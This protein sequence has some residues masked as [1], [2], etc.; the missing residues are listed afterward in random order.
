MLNKLLIKITT[1]IAVIA[2]ATSS[3]SAFGAGFSLSGK[4][5]SF[6]N[7]AMQA[8]T[9][10][11]VADSVTYTSTGSG[12][13]RTE[14]AAGNIEWA[15]TDAPYTS[16]VPSKGFVTV[17]LVA[18]P[19]AFAY[20]A[21][22]VG[23]GLNLTAEVI[24]GILKGEITR[25]N[26]SKIQSLNPRVKLPKKAIKVVYR[27]SGSGTNSNLTNYLNQTVGNWTKGSSDMVSASGGLAPGAVSF[28]TSQLLAAY[29]ED[30]SN[31]FG[32]FD[33]S[34]AINAD[35]AIAKLRNAAGVFVAP[36]S[37]A[38]GKFISGQDPITGGTD[39][40][41]GTLNINF[42]KVIPGA[43]QLSIVAYG[44]APKRVTGKVSVG[45]GKAIQD[46]FKYVVGTCMPAK[47]ALLGYA[48][49]GGKLKTSA[50]NQIKLIG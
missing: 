7:G 40:T 36:T 43:Y 17:P 37:S 21:V 27:A 9:A 14:F 24:S 42:T 49:I 39:A 31:A 2:L 29:I 25:W 44:L 34:D 38:A 13:G 4:G 41:N 5:S 32:Y 12:T 30:N 20:S 46:W 35:V 48:P 16:G 23:D 6:A 50:L 15:A 19:V 8:C 26:D 1:A 11:Y 45:K 10:A 47:A 3:S 33:L 28:S 18:G 22:G